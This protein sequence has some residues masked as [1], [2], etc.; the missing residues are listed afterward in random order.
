MPCWRRA[1]HALDEARDCN[2]GGP[3]ASRQ[4]SPSRLLCGFLK[5]AFR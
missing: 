3:S 5:P 4:F 2:I 1:E